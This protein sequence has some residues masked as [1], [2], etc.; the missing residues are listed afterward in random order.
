MYKER[1]NR[2]AYNSS[3]YATTTPKILSV[4]SMATNCPRDLCSAVSV[5][6]TGT[7]AFR[8]PVP[9]PLIRRASRGQLYLWCMVDRMQ[10][11]TEDHPYVILSSALEGST[12]D[13]PSSTERDGLDT[14]IPVSKRASDETANQRAEIVDRDLQRSE[15]PESVKD[16]Q[17]T[18]PPCSRVSS[19]TGPSGPL[20]PNFMVSW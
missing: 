17:L 1:S 10:A 12:K 6:Q 15:I 3:Q 19:M 9:Q 2:R 4:N 20:W 5:A 7:M 16:Y 18:I 13:G 11:L 14:A 8:I